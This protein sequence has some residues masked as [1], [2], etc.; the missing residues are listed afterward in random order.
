MLEMRPSYEKV[1]LQS[2]GAL[3]VHVVLRRPVVAVELGGLVF[4]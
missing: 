3:W 2:V 4:L 1:L